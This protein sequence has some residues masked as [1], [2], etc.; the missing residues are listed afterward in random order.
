MCVTANIVASISIPDT[1]TVEGMLPHRSQASGSGSGNNGSG[2][3][4]LTH[5]ITYKGTLVTTAMTPSASQ[6]EVPEVS[7]QPNFASLFSP[8]SPLFN[9]LM[10]T[11]A[12]LNTGQFLQQ[13]QQQQHQQQQQQHV[14]MPGEFQP[15][16]SCDFSTP[17]CTVSDAA[18]FASTS[19]SPG[20]AQSPVSQVSQQEHDAYSQGFGSPLTPCSAHSPEPVSYTHLTLPTTAEV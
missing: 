6:S 15:S 1:K 10:N 2:N 13:Q 4:G 9:V 14:A 8:L 11:P 5:T 20:S 12:A 3:S 19:P 7:Q 18:P 16:I 17:V